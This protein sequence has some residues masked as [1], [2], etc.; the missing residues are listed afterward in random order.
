[1]FVFP[2]LFEGFG[3]AAVEALQAGAAIV[4]S[5]IPATREVVADAAVL[6]SPGD[7]AAFA[8]AIRSILEDAELANGLRLRAKQ[9]AARFSA[10]SMI[11]GYSRLVCREAP[12]SP[13]GAVPRPATPL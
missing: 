4:A 9:R 10:N 11:D 5:D 7:A 3:L 13:T 1:V 12:R 2:S 8:K 6:V